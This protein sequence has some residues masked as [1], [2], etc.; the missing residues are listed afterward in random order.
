VESL[1][2]WEKILPHV[3]AILAA[4]LATVGTWQCAPPPIVTPPAIPPTDPAPPTPPVKPPEPK[5]DPLNAIV[6]IGAPGVGCSATIVGPRRPDGRWWVLTAAHC[7]KAGGDRWTFKIRDGR[8]G[9]FTIVS[10]NPQADF[11]WGATDAAGVDYPFALLADATPPVGTKIWHAGFGVDVPANREDGTITGGR[12]SNGQIRMRMSVSSGDS[13]GGI[14]VDA[15]GRIVS[16]VCC[17][18]GRGQTADVWGASVES[19]RS[20]QMETLG[21]DEWKPIEVPLRMSPKE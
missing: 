20:G 3:T 6:R 15:D 17:T 11:A 2:T 8:V 18:S 5:P 13:G 4:A 9:A 12:D 16:N 19:M 7:A 14:V 10:K 1:S 21:L